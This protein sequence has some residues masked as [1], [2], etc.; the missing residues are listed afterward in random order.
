[1]IVTDLNDR[2]R[3]RYAKSAT[4]MAK[5]ASDLAEALTDADD[6]K[7]AVTAA[8]LAMSGTFLNELLGI[9]TSALPVNIPDV[10]PKP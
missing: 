5:M 4:D 10:P 6:A 1:M 8:L 9:F 7:A 3:K 2:E